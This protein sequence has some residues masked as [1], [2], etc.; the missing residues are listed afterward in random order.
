MDTTIETAFAEEV[1][2]FASRITDAFSDDLSP[3]NRAWVVRTPG[4]LDVMGGIAEYSGSITLTATTGGAVLA[5]VGRRSDQAIVI[6][7][8]EGSGNGHDARTVWPLGKFY[9]GENQLTDPPAFSA[10][11]DS[12]DNTWAQPAIAALYTLLR[13]GTAPH[14]GGGMTVVFHS[15]LPP[16]ADAGL[17]SAIHATT[18][19]A[20]STALGLGLEPMQLADTCRHVESRCSGSS[21]GVSGTL[22]SLLGRPD[23]LLQ[24]RCQP[25]DLI[26][27]LRLPKGLTVV[28]IDSGYRHPLGRRKYVDARVATF[29]GQA[30]VERTL[31]TAGAAGAEWNG[32]LAQITVSEYVA[33]FRDRIPTKI[34]GQAYLERFADTGCPHARVDPNATYKIRSRTEH[35]IYENDRVHQFVERLSRVART[36]ERTALIETGELMYAS[37]WSYGQRCGLGTVATDILVNRLRQRGSAEGIYG[38]R[39]SGHGAGGVVVALI[40]DTAEARA[41]VRDIASAYE[42]E[43]GYTTALVEGSSPGTF[44]TGVQPIA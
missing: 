29:M 34:R 36:G 23:T 18:L 1:G 9:A 35:H 19:A 22:C 42:Q 12:I 26:G 24:M 5:A 33:R 7:S 17:E 25:H 13:H 4:R 6:D 32:Y 11:L 28:G 8:L 41:A 40:D 31:Q 43:T 16:G 27:P 30:F 37:H 15:T 38:A 2:L 3:A 21:G 39:V 44:V 20:A 10:M 14:F